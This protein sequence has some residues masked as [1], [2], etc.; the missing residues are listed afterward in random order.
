MYE[1]DCV[2]AIVT[3]LHH[4]QENHLPQS[5]YEAAFD[6]LNYTRFA[7]HYN[8]LKPKIYHFDNGPGFLS[9]VDTLYIMLEEASHTKSPPPP[10][11]GAM[12]VDTLTYGNQLIFETSRFRL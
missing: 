2:Q 7:N 9:L 11:I 6:R 12:M 10:N 3:S 5:D 1:H 4:I 8:Y